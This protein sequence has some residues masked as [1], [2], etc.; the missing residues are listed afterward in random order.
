MSYLFYNF[1]YFVKNNMSKIISD[2]VPMPDNFIE[3]V[4]KDPLKFI[5]G[6]P[7][8]DV[9]LHMTYE[10]LNNSS[11]KWHINDAR[12]ISFLTIAIPYAD[13]V[14]TEKKWSSVIKKYKLDKKYNTLVGSDLMDLEKM[15]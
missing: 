11:A 1:E 6:I 14:L 9:K 15:I 5:R 8:L 13:I 2:K 12:D 3:T 4:K 10:Y 7:T